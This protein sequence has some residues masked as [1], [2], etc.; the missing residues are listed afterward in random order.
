MISLVLRDF[1]LLLPETMKI[2]LPAQNI[3]HVYVPNNSF[4]GHLGG[5][6]NLIFKNQKQDSKCLLPNS[7]SRTML[8]VI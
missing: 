5:K 2:F 3:G 7:G 8:V 1:I 6:S 4:R